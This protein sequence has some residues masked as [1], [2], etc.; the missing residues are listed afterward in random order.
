MNRK[1]TS[2][3]FLSLGLLLIT[4][5]LPAAGSRHCTIGSV[6]GDWAY[7]YSGTIILPSGPIPVAT[8]GRFSAK[9]DGTFSGPQTRTVAG[10]VADETITGT[11]SL[12]SDCT[13]TYAVSVFEGGAL[14]R[15]ATLAVV[16]D[17]NETSARGI[18]TSL[19][20]PDGTQLPSV[21]TIEAKKIFPP[22]DQ[23]LAETEF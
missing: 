1:I 16:V 19:T 20:L 11:Y 4:L 12:K 15:T 3:T 5:S 21:I 18:F 17:N 13:E 10:D 14:V 8:V 6:V 23:E 22:G 2:L 9:G 7:S